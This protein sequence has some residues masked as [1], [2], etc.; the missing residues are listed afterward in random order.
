[1]FE[2]MD[3]SKKEKLSFEDFKKI[4]GEIA[5][6]YEEEDLH[7]IFLEM[8]KTKNILTFEDFDLFIEKQYGLK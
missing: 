2:I 5:V 4:C 8:S 1:M 6:K 3:N 7:E